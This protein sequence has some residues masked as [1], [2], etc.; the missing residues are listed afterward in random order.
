MNEAQ[1]KD[2]KI[3]PQISED[4]EWR[5]DENGLVTI[6]YEYED[7]V[8]KVKKLFNKESSSYKEMKLERVGSF[9]FTHIDGQK[10]FKEIADE[11]SEEFGEDVEPLYERFL[12]YASALWEK[13]YIVLL[14]NEKQDEAQ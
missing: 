4:I 14:N 7:V 13:H 2:L 12:D 1:E 10:T 6:R 5:T 9:I 3:V 8:D 11:V